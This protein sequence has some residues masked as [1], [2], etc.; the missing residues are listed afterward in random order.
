MILSLTLWSS[1]IKYINCINSVNDQMTRKTTLSDTIQIIREKKIDYIDEASI[2]SL[3]N[4]VLYA[5]GWNVFDPYEVEPQHSVY[6]GKVDLAVKLFRNRKIFIEIKKSSENLKNHEKQLKDYLRNAVDVQFGVLTNS[7]SWWFYTTSKDENNHIE[8]IR[9]AEVDIKKNKDSYIERIFSQYLSKEKLSDEWYETN[10]EILNSNSPN[11]L[12][13]LFRLR[14]MK[15]K[16][17]I[18][19]LIKIY[20]EDV[21]ESMKSSAFFGLMELHKEFGLNDGYLE[22]LL[23]IALNDKSPNIRE[24]AKK[25]QEQIK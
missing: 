1:Q 8:I 5:Y 6:N 18:E 7:T 4:G 15:D 16:R 14:S 21:D 9:E 12:S 24:Q 22:P 13:S 19:P 23:E 2:T 11:R 10:L 3:I 17:I 20:K 25:V